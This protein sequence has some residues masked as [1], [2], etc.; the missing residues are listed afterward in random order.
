MTASFRDHMIM[1]S[2]DVGRPVD[3][4]ESRCDIAKERIGYIGLSTGAT[5]APVF[6]AIERRIRWA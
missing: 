4:L 3:Y 6:L 5:L 1:W 2:K